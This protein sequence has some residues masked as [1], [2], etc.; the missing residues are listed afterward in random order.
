[1]PS[2]VAHA[3]STVGIGIS[4]QAFSRGRFKALHVVLLV[5]HATNGPD[6]GS[7][8][9]FL[10][11]PVNPTLGTRFMDV[12]HSPLGYPL[13]AG[14]GWV[15]VG[16]WL[17]RRDLVF[18]GKS[19][20]DFSIVSRRDDDDDDD[21]G[22]VR[23]RQRRHWRQ[24]RRRGLARPADGSDIG[25]TEAGAGAADVAVNAGEGD[26]EAQPPA[27]DA[28]TDESDSDDG[29]NELDVKREPASLQ[30]TFWRSWCLAQ[31]GSLL[32]YR[33]DTLYENNGAT[34]TYRWIISTG[35]WLPGANDII[36][37]SVTLAFLVTLTSLIATFAIAFTSLRTTLPLPRRVNAL[38]RTR[39]SRIWAVAGVAM[40]LA[41]GYCV[42]FWTRLRIEPRVPA[43]GEEAD[44]GVLMF[45]AATTV[46]P[47][48]LCGMACGELF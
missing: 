42:F 29:D 31:A 20:R 25:L 6:I 24:R 36:Y 35:Y 14:L 34:P 4:L 9:E 22:D 43:V 40:V 13:T 46:L 16:M 19:W 8:F 47:L 12:V 28:T 2:T 21:G 7:V 3:L 17:S 30:L 32:H 41:V 27:M 38:L 5:L 48:V 45:E 15:W 18:G 44:L 1:M 23:R 37:P 39:A 33:L 11:Q 10:M 26:E